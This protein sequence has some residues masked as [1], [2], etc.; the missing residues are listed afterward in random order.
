MAVARF[1]ASIF[2]C[3]GLLSAS[4]SVQA[5]NPFKKT[6]DFDFPDN[7]SWV[8]KKDTAVKTGRVKEGSDELFFHLSI[9]NKQLKLRFSKNDPSGMVINSRSLSSLVIEDVLVNGERLPIFQWCLNNQQADSGKFKQDTPVERNACINAE[10][11]FIINLDDRSRQILKSAKTLELVTE[12]YRRTEILNFG[13]AGYAAIAKKLDA[14]VIPA[15]AAPVI[16]VEK[17]V[18]TPKAEVKKV[19]K[20]CQATA[21]AEYTTIQSVAYP[22]ADAAKKAAAEAKIN[23]KVDAEKKKAEL[24]AAE[25]RKKQVQEKEK[26]GDAAAKAKAE[27]EWAKRQT[28]IWIKRCQKHWANMVSPCYCKSYLEHAPKGVKDTCPA[29]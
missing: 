5:E 7:V 24:A 11:D 14:P 19:V 15:K 16:A 26:T 4:M 8:L 21:P 6:I 17:P 29:D 2:L 13:M 23:Q 10:G 3:V 18:I 22:C 1:S 25:A 27:E 28:A 9:N 20:I 12:P